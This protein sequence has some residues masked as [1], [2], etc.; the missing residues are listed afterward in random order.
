[1]ADHNSMTEAGETT[2][3]KIARA[4]SVR[5]PTVAKTVNENVSGALLL[6]AMSLSS[7]IARPEQTTDLSPLIADAM[8]A[9]PLYISKDATIMDWQMHTLRRGSTK[10]T[11][12]PSR[13]APS[14][15]P[16][17]GDSDTMQFFMDLKNGKKSK[18]THI[19]I[20]YM[21]RGE[22]AA[23]FKDIRREKPPQGKDWY[24]AGP[25]VMLVF[26]AGSAKLLEGIPQDPS[27]GEPYIRPMPDG[28]AAILVL[29]VAKPLEEIRTIRPEEQ[30]SK[31]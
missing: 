1:M 21:L 5:P 24:H 15:N 13:P 17:C 11:C 30:N 29:P 28:N 6:S 3:A 27:T 25:H 22:T 31:R 26:P 8:S 23:D 7:P 16:M 10:W 12:M 19:G 18:I 4:M 20:S 14:P 2:Q 9:A